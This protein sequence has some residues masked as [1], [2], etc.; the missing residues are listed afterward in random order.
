MY[1]FW[2]SLFSLFFME[3]NTDIPDNTVYPR[4]LFGHNLNT[5]IDSRVGSGHQII[6]GRNFNSE[7][8]P[9]SDWMVGVGLKFVM[10]Q[11]HGEIHCT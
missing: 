8:L 9:L 10:Y 3:N 7:Y 11:N 6:V 5:L 2:V 1:H 4:Q